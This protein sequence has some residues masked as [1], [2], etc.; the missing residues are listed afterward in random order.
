MGA[1]ASVNHGQKMHDCFVG[2]SVN[3]GL[4]YWTGLLD[5]TSGLTFDLEFIPNNQN[6]EGKA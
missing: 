2:E 5:W 1:V 3:S 6:C 4:D